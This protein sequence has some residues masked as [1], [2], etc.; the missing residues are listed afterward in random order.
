[1][2]M[3]V[4]ACDPTTR[5]E[6]AGGPGASDLPGIHCETLSQ[7]ANKGEKKISQPTVKNPYGLT[8]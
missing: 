4:T 7:K 5:E 8:S 1:M 6:E 3:V 2:G